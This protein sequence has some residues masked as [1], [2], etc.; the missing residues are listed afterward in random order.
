MHPSPTRS[1]AAVGPSLLYGSR[2]G[3]F[4]W[5]AAPDSTHRETPDLPRSLLARCCM[6]RAW[7]RPADSAH[8]RRIEWR[9]HIGGRAGGVACARR[10]LWQPTHPRRGCSVASGQL[11]G[12]SRSVAAARSHPSGCSRSRPRRRR[13]RRRRS[14]GGH[15]RRPRRA[16]LP[17]PRL[18]DRPPSHVSRCVCARAPIFC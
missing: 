15:P 7:I 2:L 14:D 4:Q 16:P 11:L 13:A 5:A 6:L 8:P 12:C 18:P 17:A 9:L 10:H 3:C 1:R